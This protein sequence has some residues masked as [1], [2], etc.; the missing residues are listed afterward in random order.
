DNAANNDV[1]IRELS[2]LVPMFGGS[3]SHTRCFLHIVNLIAKTLIRQFDIGKQDA[4]GMLEDAWELHEL[5]QGIDE[6]ADPMKDIEEEEE[7]E[8]EAGKLSDENDG[9]MDEC[10][11]LSKEEQRELDNTVCPVKLALM[12]VS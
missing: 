4:E 6:E 3:A 12:K 2:K 7:E 9:W 8:E 1:M 5:S 11:E 10:N